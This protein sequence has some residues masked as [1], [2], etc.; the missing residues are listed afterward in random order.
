NAEKVI[1]IPRGVYNDETSRY[2]DNLMHVIAPGHVILSWTDD[3][4]D[5]QYEHSLEALTVLKNSTD[6]K[7]RKIK[8]TKLH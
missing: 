6:A 1:W 2:V 5:P 3:Q 4:N 7:G 8:V